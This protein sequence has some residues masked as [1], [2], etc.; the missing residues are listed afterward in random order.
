MKRIL[1]FFL[2]ALLLVACGGE[3]AASL[4]VDN[5]RANMAVP[6]ETGSFWMEITNS[7]DVDD[8]LLGAQVDGCGSIELHDMTM[9]DG[10]MVMREVEGGAIPIPAGETVVLEQGGLHVMCIDKAA[11]LEVGTTVNLTLEFENAGTIEVAADVVAPGEMNMDM[12]GGG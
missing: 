3:E 7:S 9:E 11:P 6:S 8:T 10:V 12:D 4:T 2:P 1:V 5:V